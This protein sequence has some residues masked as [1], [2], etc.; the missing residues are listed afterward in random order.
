MAV[1]RYMYKSL[2]GTESIKAEDV[3]AEL[4]IKKFVKNKN[5]V[6]WNDFKQIFMKKPIKTL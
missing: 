1:S 2:R 6:L 3:Y 4:F 5:K